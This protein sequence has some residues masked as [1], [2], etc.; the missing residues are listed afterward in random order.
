MVA[1]GTAATPR[2]RCSFRRYASSASR[3][4]GFG[5][6]S[7]FTPSVLATRGTSRILLPFARQ[8]KA[9]LNFRDAMIE[10]DRKR[11]QPRT[12]IAERNRGAVL[13]GGFSH[14]PRWH[15]HWIVFLSPP[16]LSLGDRA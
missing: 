8:K 14:V 10:R 2:S 9:K 6:R 1:A 16:I 3:S 4:P 11:G 12:S 7:T 15:S 13:V 5:C